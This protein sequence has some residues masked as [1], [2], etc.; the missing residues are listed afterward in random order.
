MLVERTRVLHDVALWLMAGSVLAC[1][2]HL[3]IRGVIT[4]GEV[5]VVSTLTFRI[6]QGSRDLAWP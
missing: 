4:P 5:V 3:W 2:V 1:V 6:L